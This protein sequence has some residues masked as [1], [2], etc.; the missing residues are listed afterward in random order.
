MEETNPASFLQLN[1]YHSKDANNVFYSGEPI[2]SAHAATFEVM[3]E[4]FGRD[5]TSVYFKGTALKGANP[6]SFELL[7]DYFGRDDRAV[8]LYGDVIED[9]DP[10]TFEVL[11]ESIGMDKSA[12]YGFGKKLKIERETFKLLDPYLYYAFYA[13]DQ[14]NLYHV[15]SGKL[16]RLKANLDKLVVL[17]EG[18]IKDDRSVWWAGKK[19]DNAD[20]E[21]FQILSIYYAKD[22][23]QVYFHS[24][25]SGFK[26]VQGADAKAFVCMEMEYGTDADNLYYLGELSNDS[27]GN[28]DDRI[29]GFIRNNPQMQGY[30]W[31]RK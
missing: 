21:S 8:Y 1:E 20:P 17:A 28:D 31:N 18:F 22:K 30:W 12:V 27:K 24:Y 15:R 14:G 16:T 4:W 29:W 3:T 13:R 25:Y 10:S 5:R 9:A 11:A 6:V 23:G 26:I 2:E 7:S 19:I